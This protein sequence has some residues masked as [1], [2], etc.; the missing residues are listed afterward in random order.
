MSVK[1]FNELGKEV[2]CCNDINADS[3]NCFS[4]DTRILPAGIYLLNVSSEGNVYN[5][6][7]VVIK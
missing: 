7:V 3:G 2:Y 4:I 1:L 5:K 6:K